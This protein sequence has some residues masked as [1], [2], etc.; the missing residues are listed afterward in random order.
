[1]HCRRAASA[2]PLNYPNP[3]RVYGETRHGVLF[4]GYDR[5]LEISFVVAECALVKVMSANEA[6]RS[7]IPEHL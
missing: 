1:M 6:G 7:Q 5:A 4:G 2:E 3:S